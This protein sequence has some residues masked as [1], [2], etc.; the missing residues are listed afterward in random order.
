MKVR[1][2]I[3]LTIAVTIALCGCG[4]GGASSST[5]TAKAPTPA[6]GGSAAV[7]PP[8]GTPAALRGVHGGVLLAGDLPGFVPKGYRPPSTSPQSWVAEFP[9]EQRA[10]EAARLKALG[11]LAGITEQLAPANGGAADQEAISLVEQFRSA[12]GADGEI[13]SQLTQARIRG[14]KAF[15][16]GGI[17]GARGWGSSSTSTVANVEFAIGPYYYL[18]G[19][20]A[21]AASAPT[22]AQLIAAAQRLYGR[23]HA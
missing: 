15:A 7:A 4:G 8:P 3:V 5:T 14:E 11:F 10:A 16:V 2:V 18:V 17:P 1:P 19:F 23:V 12:Q 6:S 22:H 9:P 13:A 21:P 20:S